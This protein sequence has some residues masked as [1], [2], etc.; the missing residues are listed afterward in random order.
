[1][2]IQNKTKTNYCGSICFSEESINSYFLVCDFMLGDADG[3]KQIIQGNWE[4]VTKEFTNMVLALE[5]A[6]SNPDEI[7]VMGEYIET[8]YSESAYWTFEGYE[9][10][11]VDKNKD[12]FICSISF[13]DEETA[14]IKS[15][16]LF[17]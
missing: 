15:F 10:F 4:K 12:I 8:P 14:F 2:N 1:M 17:Q 7:K 9:I 5:V 3:D 6:P 11:F 16:T 13:S